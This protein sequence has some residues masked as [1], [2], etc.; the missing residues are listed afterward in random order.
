MYRLVF[1]FYRMLSSLAYWLV[2][3]FTVAGYAV[4]AGLF[5]TAISGVDIEK[6]VTYQAFVFLFCLVGV[7]MLCSLRFKTDIRV[8]RVLPRFGS[9]G[10]PIP[11]RMVIHNQGHESQAGLVLMEELVDPRPGYQEFVAQM[12][13]DDRRTGSFRIIK[14]RPPKLPRFHAKIKEQA[15]PVLPVGE[16]VN[17][18]LEIH[19][20]RRGVVRFTGVVMARPDPFGLFKSFQRLPLPGTVLILPKRYVLPPIPL[21]GSMKYQ[22]GGVAMASSVGESEEFVSLRDYR[23]GDP[24]RHIH[25]RSWARFGEPIVKEFQDEFFVRHA[26]ILDTFLDAPESLAFEEAVSI[27]ASFACTIQ[28]Q[29]SLLD[30]LF[31]GAQA[32]CFTAGRGLAYT[33]QMLEILA[34]VQTC[35]TQ[36]FET[37]QTL[38]LNHASLVSGC[39]VILLAWDESRRELVKKLRLLGVPLLVLVITEPGADLPNQEQLPQEGAFYI[40][41]AGRIPDGLLNLKFESRP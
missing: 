16:T 9:V 40:L 28:T 36:S 31:V 41:E 15:L 29:E 3:R 17:V 11:Y 38:V 20:V 37:L 1:T 18:N 8:E 14:K 32:Y 2:R 34:A 10:Q 6:T 21:P 25:W 22:Q 5:I 39:I 12:K 35:R 30:L 23:P 7:S 26:L 24:L 27:A 19:P 4:L 33:E 13:S